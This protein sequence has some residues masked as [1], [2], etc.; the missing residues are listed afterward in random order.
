[1]QAATELLPG[2]HRARVADFASAWQPIF[3]R[4]RALRPTTREAVA[5]SLALRRAARRA[6]VK[7]V[8]PGC[9]TCVA[10][11]VAA[12][13]GGTVTLVSCYEHALRDVAAAE[14]EVRHSSRAA[15]PR[16]EAA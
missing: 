14:R 9:P 12:L 16:A 11:L 2:A 4:V 6:N 1:M 8:E 13:P 10:G 7:P 15:W 5:W 3:E